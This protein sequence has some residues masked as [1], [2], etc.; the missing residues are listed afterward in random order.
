LIYIDFIHIT[1][2]QAGCNT[3]KGDNLSHHID[4]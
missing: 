3:F 4:G 1:L 2:K